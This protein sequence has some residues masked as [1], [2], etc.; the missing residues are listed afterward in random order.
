MGD[1][2][3]DEF[4]SALSTSMQYVTNGSSN[5]AQVRVIINE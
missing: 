2:T 5:A 3:M 1:Q 4:C